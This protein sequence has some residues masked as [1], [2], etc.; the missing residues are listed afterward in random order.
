MLLYI[1]RHGDPIYATDSLT[2]RGKL[3]AE[4][5]A[6]RI[7]AEK[8]DEIYC[9]PMGRARMTAEPTC[10]LLGLD[11]KVEEWTHEILTQNLH[12]PFPDGVKK[13]LTRVQNTYYRENGNIE[14]PYNDS[15]DCPGF[16][17]SGMKEAVSYIEEN[18]KAFLERLGYRE[19]NGIYRIIEPNEKK[20]A[21]FC[22]GAFTRAWLS[23]LLH[24]PIHI[25]WAGFGVTH[26]SVTLV[27][28]KNNENGY[29]APRCL[30][31]SDMGHLYAHGPDTI[32]D[33]HTPEIKVE[34]N[35]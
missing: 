23:V 2:E 30:Y 31:L 33:F 25:V 16:N 26:A 8:I 35:T 27:E 15:Y 5:V 9:S 6:K 20:I 14:L 4:A 34:E 10:R 17:E 28:F 21:L 32:Y 22:H 24:I 3:Q 13:S 1:I 19:E 12:T 11:Y 18:G 7:A 29:T